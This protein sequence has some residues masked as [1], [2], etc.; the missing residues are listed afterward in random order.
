M[1]KRILCDTCRWQNTVTGNGKTLRFCSSIAG[2]DKIPFPVESCGAYTE[3]NTQTLREMQEVALYMDKPSDKK[4]IGFNW[5]RRDE[6]KK[7]H[8]Y[9][10]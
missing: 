4:E 8:F 5:L 10:D 2:F 9:E 1:T 3:K 6:W 7:N